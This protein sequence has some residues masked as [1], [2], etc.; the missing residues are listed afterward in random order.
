MESNLIIEEAYLCGPT[1]N[2]WFKQ[3]GKF[4]IL[5]LDEENPDQIHISPARAGDIGLLLDGCLEVV[6]VTDT[7]KGSERPQEQLA[8][9][10]R[11]QRG[12]YDALAFTLNGLNPK[13]KDKTR[14]SGVKLAEK[15]CQTEEVYQFVRQRLLNRP[16]A[17]GMDIQ[18]AVELSKDSPRMAQLYQAVQALSAS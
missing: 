4:Y 9:L 8:E 16:L 15:L 7:I 17:K 1:G 13:L 2:A 5:S 18:K 3:E 14:M 10:L 12:T 11:S 6:E